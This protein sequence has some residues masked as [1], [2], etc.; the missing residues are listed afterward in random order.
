MGIV[1]C[2]GLLAVLWLTS[3]HA[4]APP[5]AARLLVGTPGLALWL[6]FGLVGMALPAFAVAGRGWGPDAG[7]PG[8]WHRGVLVAAPIV[9]GC[10][11]RLAVLFGGQ[12][13]AAFV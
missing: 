12:G 1:V 3:V 13:A 10:C 7:P 4:A 11:L 2:Q 6:G 8:P 5:V 9:G